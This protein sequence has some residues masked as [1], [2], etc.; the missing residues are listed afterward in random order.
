MSQGF[1]IIRARVKDDAVVL[2]DRLMRSKQQEVVFVLPKNSIIIADLNSL[3][4]LK[5]EGWFHS[6]LLEKA[7]EDIKWEK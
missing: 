2:I 1:E 3:K 6:Y 4:I 5:E 7:A